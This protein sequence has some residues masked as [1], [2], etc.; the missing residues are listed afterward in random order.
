MHGIAIGAV[1]LT[2]LGATPGMPIL[3]QILQI[4]PNVLQ[5]VSQVVQVLPQV[6]IGQTGVYAQGVL[7]AGRQTGA[8]AVHKAPRLPLPRPRPRGHH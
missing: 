3:T 1:A 4:I 7:P 8:P 2:L 6:Q 5:G